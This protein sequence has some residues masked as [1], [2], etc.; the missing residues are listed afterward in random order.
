MIDRLSIA[1]CI[2]HENRVKFFRPVARA[3]YAACCWALSAAAALAAPVIINQPFS[4]RP[5]DVISLQGSG[6]GAAPHV[7]MKPLKQLIPTVLATKTADDGTVVVQAP[8]AALFDVYEVWITNGAT[9]SNHVLL[10]APKPMHFDNAEIAPGAHFRIFGRNLYV[11]NIPPTVTLVDV[12]TKAPAIATVTTSTSSAYSLDVTPSLG[13]IPGH[14]YQ[15]NVSNGYASTLSAASIVAHAS[16]T[17]HFLIGQPW[18]YDFV[19]QDGPGYQAGVKGTNQADHHVFNVRTDPSLAILAKGDGVT[20]DGAAIQGAINTAAAHRG[21]VYLPA[22]TYNIGSVRVDL[23]PGVV[24]QGESASNTKIIFGPAAPAGF[25]VDTG[26]MSGFADL[27]IQNVDL[28]SNPITNIGT[29]GQPISKFFIQRVNWNLGSGAPIFLKGDRIA[30]LNSTF[31]QAINYQTGSVAQKTGG[32]GPLYFSQ[33]S[34]LQFK[35][36]TIKWATNQN[37]MNDLVNAII[38]NNHFT[39]SASDTIVAGPAQA[40]WTFPFT[41]QPVVAGETVSRVDGRQLSINFGKNVVVQNNLF[42][43]SDGVLIVNH[44]DGETILNEAGGQDM[45][46]DWGIVTTA[47]SISVTDNSKCSGSGSGACAWMVYPNSMLVIISGAGAGQWR[48]ITA[49][50]GNTFTV[51]A[52]FDV[53]PAAG[54][55]FSI[56]VPTYENAIISNNTATGNPVGIAMYHGAYLNVAVTGNQL[57]NNGG[58]YLMAEQQ[59]S[60][61]RSEPGLDATRNME[62]N[63]NT[64]TNTTGAWPSYIALGYLMINPSSFWGRNVM[65]AEIRNNS[66][67]AR[68]GTPYY[69]F[70]EGYQAFSFYQ[71]YPAAYVEQQG[72]AFF[73]TV[74]QGN[75]CANCTVNYSLGTGATDTTIWNAATSN[76][77]GV[78]STFLKDTPMLGSG[79]AASIRTLVGHD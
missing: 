55:R 2:S 72:G 14:S 28:S 59:L 12:A 17:D 43:V 78:T 27:T 67:A 76:S 25:I 32:L 48:H 34:N 64:L 57:T 13:V 63:G 73:G 44:N 40:S 8:K 65:G 42:D 15:V 5:G 33:L 36:N 26:G 11:N 56:A 10:N 71:A 45:R 21:V 47:N 70:A 35:N 18:A 54:D 19:Y 46:E 74:F 7:Y 39:R 60:S 9:T 16:G 61:T 1:S 62:I 53:A 29:W 79:A 3:S 58:I 66:I 52:P 77:P 31:T 20:N 68:T 6:F 30:I 4:A 75:S 37:S 50:V 38:E 41:N 23:K 49:H 22:G 51:D 69:F 24:L